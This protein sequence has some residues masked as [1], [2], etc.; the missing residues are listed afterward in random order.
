MTL[1]KYACAIVLVGCVSTQVLAAQDAGSGPTAG[2][3]SKN[4]AGSGPTQGAKSNGGS[5]PKTVSPNGQ[6]A[7][8]G[9]TTGSTSANDA[10]SG[11]TQGATK[12]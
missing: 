8:S 7:G 10:G 11:P 1:I 6:D 12:P 2:A 9:P 3:T 4:D 5:Q